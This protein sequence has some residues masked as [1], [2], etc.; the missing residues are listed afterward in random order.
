MEGEESPR[1]VDRLVP[2]WDHPVGVFCD[3]MSFLDEDFLDVVLG[4][5]GHSLFC[6]V[7]LLVSLVETSYELL[8]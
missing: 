7:S 4:G 6:V 8:H 5:L 2:G 3:R 1:T